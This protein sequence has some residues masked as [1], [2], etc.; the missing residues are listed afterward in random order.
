[1]TLR[2]LVGKRVELLQDERWAAHAAP[3]RAGHR[4]TVAV[5]PPPEAAGSL[6]HIC[7][8]RIQP[9][10]GGFFG[11]GAPDWDFTPSRQQMIRVLEGDAP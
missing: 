7:F 11:L 9:R 3:I 8:D 1:M 4:G 2:D 5:T 6:V 10:P